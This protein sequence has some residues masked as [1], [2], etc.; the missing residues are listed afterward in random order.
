MALSL[1][2]LEHANVEN[3]EDDDPDEQLEDP[4]VHLK[5]ATE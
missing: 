4:V 2:R 3:E 5:S 1:Y